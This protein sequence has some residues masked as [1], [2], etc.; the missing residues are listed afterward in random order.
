MSSIISRCA[1][2]PPVRTTSAATGSRMRAQPAWSPSAKA[3]AARQVAGTT[4]PV[5][6]VL[7]SA[8]AVS[9]VTRRATASRAPGRPRV[10]D[11]KQ[12]GSL[13]LMVPFRRRP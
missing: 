13:S 8:S 12:P 1:P 11:G 7:A 2:L 3:S 10:S 5:A 4:G 6:R 9:A